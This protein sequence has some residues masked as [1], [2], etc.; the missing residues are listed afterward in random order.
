MWVKVLSYALTGYTAIKLKDYIQNVSLES[1]ISK[2]EDRV[3]RLNTQHKKRD[4]LKMQFREKIIE[5]R[6]T[7]FL[8][9]DDTL[10]TTKSNLSAYL[11]TS[12][13][14]EYLSIWD[15]D[16]K[17]CRIE[18]I[19]CLEGKDICF[20]KLLDKNK[21][22]SDIK[23]VDRTKIGE[24]VFAASM[25]NFEPSCQIVH[26]HVHNKVDRGNGIYYKADVH[27]EKGSNG[28][29]LFNSSGYLV[30]MMVECNHTGI[31]YALTSEEIDDAYKI[32]TGKR[33]IKKEEQIPKF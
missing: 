4:M 2:A 5:T 15:K 11:K 28:A 3:Y 21:N 10:V 7:A 26:G 19:G 32:I 20:M 8:Y 12:A 27:L 24:H 18:V 13:T 33:D 30:G 9:K 17:K 16:L 22:H 14:N 31:S 1:S 25:P 23:T 6:G 29:P